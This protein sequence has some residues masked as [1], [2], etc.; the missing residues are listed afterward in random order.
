[1]AIRQPESRPRQ[2]PKISIPRRPAWQS[3]YHGVRMSPEQYLALPEVKPYLE[4]VD[5]VV[6]QKPMAN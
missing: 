6:L 2:R 3:R 5:G 4:Y 1:M